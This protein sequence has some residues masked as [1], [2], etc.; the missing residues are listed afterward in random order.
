MS[1]W[2]DFVKMKK[3]VSRKT[4]IWQVV[5]KDGGVLL[6]LISWYAPWRKYCFYPEINCIFETT[7]LQ[8]IVGFIINRME[9]RKH[10]PK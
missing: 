6:G 9:D 10:A 1:R 7:C 4:D 2:I 5:A 8:D 3:P